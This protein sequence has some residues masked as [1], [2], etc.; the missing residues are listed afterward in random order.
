MSEL[1]QRIDAVEPEIRA[2][3]KTI[4]ANPELGLELDETAALIEA[5]LRAHTNVDRIHRVGRSGIWVELKGTKPGTGENILML[6]GDMDA[7][8]IQEATGLPYESKNPGK[9]HACGHDVHASSLLG[10]VRVLEQY[11]DQIDGSIWFF[12]Q[13]G[14]EVLGGALE[15]LNDP[16][17]DFTKVKACAACHVLGFNE[18]GKI[19]LRDGAHLAS[20][21]DLRITVSGRSAHSSTPDATVDAIVIAAELICQLQ[22]MISREV[23]PTDSV[24]LTLGKITGG[25]TPGSVADEVVIEGGLRTIHPATRE[26]ILGRIQTICDG[27]ALGTRSTIEMT[28]H[29][30]APALHNDHRMFEIAS[31]AVKRSLGED[32]LVIADVYAMA[33]EDFAFFTQYCPGIHMSI[34]CRTPGRAPV[35]AHTPQF[36]TDEGTVRNAITAYCAF[37]LEYFGADY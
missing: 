10:A 16:E 15:F 28:Y 35:V 22:C 33:S 26:R 34:G 29:N 30:R 3:W 6:R 17:I 25:K 19:N 31:A 27:L 2:I 21:D 1:L 11:R 20:P 12:F 37:A 9:M 24:I 7:L 32:A 23:N 4:H 5:E 8:P 18:V 36:Y 14:E 13:P